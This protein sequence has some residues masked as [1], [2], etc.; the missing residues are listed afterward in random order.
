MGP[1][2]LPL[3]R[4]PN[5][6]DDLPDNVGAVFGGTPDDPRLPVTEPR[7][8]EEPQPVDPRA[9]LVLDRRATVVDRSRDP[10]P[11]EVGAKPGGEDHGR[12]PAVRKVKLDGRVERHGIAR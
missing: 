6:R 10:Q 5:A 2:V 11:R 4:R 1:P 3:G 8:T 9:A 7:P 12:D